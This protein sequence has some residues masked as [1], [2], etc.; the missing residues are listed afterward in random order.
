MNL[1]IENENILSSYDKFTKNSKL[2]EIATS[3]STSPYKKIEKTR[4]K[5]FL[6]DARLL[7][8]PGCSSIN[9]NDMRM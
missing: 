7:I 1:P 6:G 3:L 2:L 8:H 9:F 5:I 4:N